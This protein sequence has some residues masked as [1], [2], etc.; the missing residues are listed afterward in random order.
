MEPDYLASIEKSVFEKKKT[1][2]N[3]C[4]QLH[5]RVL[6]YGNFLRKV[7]NVFRSIK[8]IL[9]ELDDRQTC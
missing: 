1:R 2:V 9:D 6:F 4:N 5:V 8:Y 7:N 3:Y